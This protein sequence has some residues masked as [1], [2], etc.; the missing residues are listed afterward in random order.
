MADEI[1]DSGALTD[2]NDWRV[3]VRLH[4]GGQAGRAAEH[5]SAHR[6]ENEAHHRLGG[7]VVVGVGGDSE[8]FLYTHTEQ[9]AATA[10]QSVSEL[11]ASH[12]LQADYTVDRWH[13]VAEEWESADVALPDTP[14]GI[15]AERLQLDEAETSASLG[16]GVALFE[17]RVQLPTHR[18]SVMLAGQLRREGYSVLRRWR[19]LVVGANNADQA[20]EFAAAIQREAPAGSVVTTEEVG[21]ARPYTPFEIAAGSGI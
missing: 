10:R 6:V 19:F 15:E 3:T 21:P 7:R 16:G 1:P 14:A 4:E 8:L 17:V 11:L 12:G 5:L 20:G 13:P 18:E 2:A 9:A